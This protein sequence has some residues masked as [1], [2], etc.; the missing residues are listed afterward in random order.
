MSGFEVEEVKR[1]I[2]EAKIIADAVDE[3]LYTALVKVAQGFVRIINNE[4][5][6]PEV[7]GEY[8]YNTYQ[9]N[10]NKKN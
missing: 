5:F 10:L 8:F 3:K 6:V 9:N 2:N 4:D 7:I 1:R